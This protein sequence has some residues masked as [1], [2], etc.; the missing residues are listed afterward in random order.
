MLQ[1]LCN[2][3]D[4]SKTERIEFFFPFIRYHSRWNSLKKEDFHYSLN[5]MK[6]GSTYSG[7]LKTV[8]DVSES[9]SLTSCRTELPDYLQTSLEELL[10]YCDKEQIKIL[11][12]TAPQSKNDEYLLGL[13]NSVNDLVSLRG[14]PVLNMMEHIN[15]IGLDF[16]KDYYNAN[17]TN[18]HGAIKTTE[19]LSQYLIKNYGFKSKKGNLNYKE[20][21][22]AYEKYLNA[23]A[24]YV[25]INELDCTKRDYTLT[26][27]KL[28][29]IK[30][31]A[32]ALTLSWETVA[33][34]DGYEIYRKHEN[35][36]WNLI[37]TLECTNQ[38]LMSYQDT[39]CK[40]G[41]KYTYT[42]MPYK[43]VKNQIFY[44]KYDF[45]GINATA[46]LKAPRLTSLSGDENNATLTW[47]NVKGADGYI[48]YRKKVG[49]KNWSK[50]KDV[51]LE[52]S[53]TDTHMIKNTSYCYT[54]KA[55]QTINEKQIIGLCDNNGL[56][57][58]TK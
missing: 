18:V 17:H 45:N 41:K 20:W 11:F 16:T 57:Y 34:A 54:V 10:D 2:I 24:P 58:T 31:G 55:Y 29:K 33:G 42:L 35:D 1:A 48:V 50:I 9:Y 39:T 44:G 6:G 46:I 7:Y 47:E 25:V 13:Y 12:V 23:I 26:E 27:P 4:F 36:A 14:Y 38:G 52:H 22:L 51:K 37:A 30:V 8:N 40:A 56:T 21:E 43:T 19:Y 28:E 32:N 15:E 3:S 49:Q 53:Y 5:G